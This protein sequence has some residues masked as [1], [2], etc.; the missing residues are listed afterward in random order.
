MADL[1]P[2]LLK[3]I[4]NVSFGANLMNIIA[5]RKGEV[6]VKTKK[7]LVTYDGE[8]QEPVDCQLVEVKFEGDNII[9][10][11]VPAKNVDQLPA[12][13]D[14]PQTKAIIPAVV[15]DKFILQGDDLEALEALSDFRKKENIAE[16]TDNSKL[17]AYTLES[18]AFDIQDLTSVQNAV[19]DI[20]EKEKQLIDK[21][22]KVFKTNIPRFD[23]ENINNFRLIE[24]AVLIKS[25]AIVNEKKINK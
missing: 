16:K 3:S 17:V 7:L 8:K 18:G 10:N 5:L 9:L 22:Y 4:D 2:V 13:K 19:L 6:I 14:T 21:G 24:S 20:I 11:I 12:A 1:Y 23:Y 25:V 15:T